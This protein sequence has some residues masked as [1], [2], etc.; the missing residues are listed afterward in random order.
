MPD[1]SHVSHGPA[2]WDKFGFA[3]VKR[4]I[5]KVQIISNILAYY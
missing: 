1:F 3:S 2:A 5:C 4:D